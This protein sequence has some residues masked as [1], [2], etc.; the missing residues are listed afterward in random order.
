M[1]TCPIDASVVD[2]FEFFINRFSVIG[3]VW[4]DTLC[5]DLFCDKKKCLLVLRADGR[6][7]QT[8]RIS[9]MDVS[10]V[11]LGRSIKRKIRDLKLDGR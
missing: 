8:R 10:F 11:S 5:L 6:K 7:G 2:R 4:G 3:H 9:V 1:I